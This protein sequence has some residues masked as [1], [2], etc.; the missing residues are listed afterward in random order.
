MNNTWH[1]PPADDPVIVGPATAQTVTA[2]LRE[3]LAAD[4]HELLQGSEVA[5]VVTRCTITADALRERFV[6]T[7]VEPLATVVLAAAGPMLDDPESPLARALRALVEQVEQDVAT[8]ER[9]DT[10]PPVPVTSRRWP[11][12]GP[13]PTRAEVLRVVE[14]AESGSADPVAAVV[15]ALHDAGMLAWADEPEPGH[16]LD[17]VDERTASALQL[18]GRAPLPALTGAL[19]ADD[20]VDHIQREAERRTCPEPHPL[21]GAPCVILVGEH[22]EHLDD[23][24]TVHRTAAREWWTQ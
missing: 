10:Y 5:A 23:G 7:V 21:N 22:L 4:R 2:D 15:E 9:G 1:N 19:A 8:D 14:A 12:R 11:D 3:E 13:L 24:D 20:T 6:G 18:I 17:K 16:G